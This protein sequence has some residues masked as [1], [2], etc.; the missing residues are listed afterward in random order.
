MLL[1]G[2]QLRSKLSEKQKLL[3]REMT[4]NKQL[5]ERLVSLYKLLP[6]SKKNMHCGVCALFEKHNNAREYFGYFSFFFFLLS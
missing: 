5:S 4:V 1:H 2:V 6:D 3:E